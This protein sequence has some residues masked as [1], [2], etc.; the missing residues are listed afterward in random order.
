M[1]LLRSPAEQDD[2][3]KRP[4][5]D[6]S[7]SVFKP[8]FAEMQALGFDERAARQVLR[9]TLG[10]TSTVDDVDEARQIEEQLHERQFMSHAEVK[11]DGSAS[12]ENSLSK[13]DST[14]KEDGLVTRTESRV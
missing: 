9:I 13:Y 3:S 5:W 1:Q 7:Y 12:A 11:K 6:W 10:R 2:F 14:V 4:W 8:V